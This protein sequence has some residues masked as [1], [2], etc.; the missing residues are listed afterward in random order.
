MIRLIAAW[1][2][3]AALAFGL[4]GSPAQAAPK[5]PEPA[6]WTIQKPNGATITLFGSVHLLPDGNSWRTKAL[7]DS[8]ARADVIVLETDLTVMEESATQAYLAAHA[9]NEAGVTLSSLLTPE[10][11]AT[12]SKGATI[13]GLSLAAMESYRPWFAALQMTVAY[14]QSQGFKS[15][16]GVDNMI[17]AEGKGDGKAFDY[18]ESAREQLDVFIELPQRQQ[19]DFLTIGAKE[20]QDRPDEMTKLVKAWAEGDVEQIDTLMNQGLAETPEIAEALLD[21]RNGRWVKKIL[22]FYMKD[23]NSYL[24]VVG[25][26]HLAGSDGVPAKLREAGVDVEGP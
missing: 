19:I 3:T 26:G 14:A 4:A 9:L 12:V 25:A 15:D 22:T 11:K 2:A 10:Q 8:Y 7:G 24:I 21:D 16:K 1:A 5:K 13:A 20:L 17:E 6:I 23:K 18:F